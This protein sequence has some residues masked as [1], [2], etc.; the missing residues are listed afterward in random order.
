VVLAAWVLLRSVAWGLP[1]VN[2]VATDVLTNVG[3]VDSAVQ[4]A[5]ALVAVVQIG[6]AGVVPRPWNWAP[7]WA[8][9]A[10]VVPSLLGL[11][12]LAVGALQEPQPQAQS[13]TLTMFVSALDGLARTVGP[14]FLG[15]LAIV[16]GDRMGRAQAVQ[17]P[18]EA[19]QAH[20]S[21]S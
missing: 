4:L 12:L 6:R 1:W 13:L 9:G 14:V 19:R 8:L 11:L 20:A 18:M 7:A 2:A 10:V 5:A 16:L 17:V 15:V 3:Y 21:N